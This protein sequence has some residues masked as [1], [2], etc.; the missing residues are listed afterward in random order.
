ME[1]FFVVME[2]LFVVIKLSS[3]VMESLS[4]VMESVFAFIVLQFLMMTSSSD[5]V[6]CLLAVINR[7]PCIVEWL[8][9]GLPW[10]VDMHINGLSSSGNA[11]LQQ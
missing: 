7:F 1:S 6:G 3:S 9:H 8:G 11:I 4:A 5:D 10:F 2:S